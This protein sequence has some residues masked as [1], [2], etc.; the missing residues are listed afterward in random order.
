MN[1]TTST[2]TGPSPYLLT[3]DEIAVINAARMVCRN[4]ARRLRT[5]R[6]QRPVMPEQV[7]AHDV[8]YIEH[9]AG[10]ADDA[11]FDLLNNVDAYLHAGLARTQV[12][13]TGTRRRS[14]GIT[15]P[16]GTY[17]RRAL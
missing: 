16:F 5:S 10:F 11:L 9:A 2:E 13:A 8:G 4:Y 17:R 12:K 3:D 15:R 6:W 1:E 14:P 7:T